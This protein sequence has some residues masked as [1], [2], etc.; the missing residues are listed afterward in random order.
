MR[1][2]ALELEHV[3]KKFKRGEFHNSLR[4]LIPAVTG[5][6][7]RRGQYGRSLDVRDFWALED[8]SFAVERGEAF[9][10]IGSN[11]A[12]KSTML[13]LLS[14][15]LRPSAGEIKINGRLSALDPRLAPAS[16]PI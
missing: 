7:L 6:L 2:V 11:G 5:K 10:I 12:G 4:D 3:S 15:I 9:G 13:K 8:V 14:R 16:I 1:T